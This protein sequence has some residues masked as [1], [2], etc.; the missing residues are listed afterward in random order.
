M[1]LAMMIVSY[2]M[3]LTGCAVGIESHNQEPVAV[4]LAATN[5][6]VIAIDGSEIATSADSW[7]KM[8]ET[9]QAGCQEEAKASGLQVSFQDGAARATGEPGTLLDFYI[10]DFRHIS[11][12]MLFYSGPWLGN[13]FIDANTKF[14]DLQNSALWGE[15]PYRADKFQWDGR[16][17]PTTAKQAQAICKKMFD[18]IR[19]V[20]KVKPKK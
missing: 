16:G 18:V 13:P 15:R 20:E 9:L 4:G 12:G 1:R 8:K 7:P 10:N 2:S 3:V 11:M 14:L 17:S 5:K 6:V 19:G